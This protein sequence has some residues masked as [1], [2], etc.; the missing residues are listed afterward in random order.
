MLKANPERSARGVIIEAKI[1]KNKGPV[2]TVLIQT[3]TLN[4]SEIVVVG[5][6]RG[7][8]KAMVNDQGDR[9]RSAGPSQPVEILG[10]NGLPA[11]GE[12]MVVASDDKTAKKLVTENLVKKEHQ[13]QTIVSL[14]DVYTRIQSGDIKA[15]NLIVKTDVQGSIDAV[16]QSL[17]RINT[18]QYKVNLIRLASGGITENDIL[19]AIASDAIVIG[20]NS[21]PEPGARALAHQTG[22]E[23]KNYDI[24]YN[25]IDD[26]QKALTGLLEPVYKEVLEGSATIRAV[27]SLSKRIKAAG[28]YVNDGRIARDSTIHILRDGE[29]MFVGPITSLKHFKDDVR[30]VTSGF[31]GGL[32]V[33]GFSDY[34]ED[35]V[36]EAYRSERVD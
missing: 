34:Q 5:D 6:V 21:K 27:F 24:I 8:V 12:T 25:L 4:V 3:G 19:L 7:R 9:I 1:D 16:R 18:E 22:I 23:I 11:A 31:E 2:A 10:L 29:R 15:L 32:A 17:E 14:E 35:D 26:V 33:E 13:K 30:E 36:L 20:F 28:I